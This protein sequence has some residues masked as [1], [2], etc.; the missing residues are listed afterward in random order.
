MAETVD[1]A[2][3][4]GG[5]AG[6]SAAYFLARLGV[7]NVLVLE[8]SA[9]AAGASGRASGLVSM[10]T[11][12]HPGCA[13]LLK[14]SAD[15]YASWER[16]IDAPAAVSWVGGLRPVP[17]AERA[18]LQEEVRIMREAGHEV[19]ILER[20]AVEALVQGWDLTGIDLAAYSPRAG[21]IDPPA[22][23]T[24]LM[25]RARALGA[26]VYQGADVQ[27]LFLQGGRVGGLR[28]T[29]GE[30]RTGTVIVATGAWLGGPWLPE[31]LRVALQPVRHMV[32][33]LR[34]PAS[35]R[36]PFPVTGDLANAVYFRPEPGGLVL[37]AHS[38]VDEPASDPEGFD[39]GADDEYLRQMLARLTR[40]IPAMRDAEIVGGHAGVYLAGADEFPILGRLGD[41]DGLYCL[42]D[43]A[44]NGMTSSPGLGRAL[45]ETI[46]RGHTFT[47]IAPF[48]PGRFA[49]GEP[50]RVAYRHAGEPLAAPR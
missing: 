12:G 4:G 6:A 8:R 22:V 11:T 38:G 26:R 17:G 49:E 42:A 45:A 1:V 23:T 46:V 15:F 9:V 16:E 50:I 41:T 19:A 18:D 44:G 2:I 14:A 33:H 48:R 31:G 5:I 47:D 20:E 32:A 30:I 3:I 43:T 28:S 25:N 37:A 29:R 36:W 40:R 34:P 39:P 24:A 10:L 21:Y 7:R 35:L 13:A 27:E